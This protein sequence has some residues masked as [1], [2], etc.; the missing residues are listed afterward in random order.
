AVEAER[1]LMLELQGGCQ[2]PIGAIAHING[3]TLNLEAVICSL[4]GKRI[5]RDS[6]SGP[7]ARTRETG[8]ELAQKLLKSGGREILEEIRQADY[9]Q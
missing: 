9:G 2:V 1:A 4:D 3:S 8:T 7:V 6:T 5:I